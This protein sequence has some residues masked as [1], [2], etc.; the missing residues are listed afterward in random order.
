MTWGKQIQGNFYCDSCGKDIT[1]LYPDPIARLPICNSSRCEAAYRKRHHKAAGDIRDRAKHI[2][3]PK[4]GRYVNAPLRD[5][6]K[7]RKARLGTG[8][9]YVYLSRTMCTQEDLDLLPGSGRIIL[10]HRLV[11]AKHLGQPIPSGILVRHINGDKMD[12]RPENLQLGTHKDNSM[13]N[14]TAII[15]A[16]KWRRIAMALFILL[17]QKA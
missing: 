12:N 14:K 1:D 2:N 6:V 13:D 10:L 16:N 4:Y 3:Q 15:E 9:G 7:E 17:Q 11:L 8:H 5:G